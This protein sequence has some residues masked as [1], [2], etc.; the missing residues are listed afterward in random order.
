MTGFLSPS[1]KLGYMFVLGLWFLHFPSLCISP[2]PFY[3]LPF[4]LP[5][6]DFY[7]FIWTGRVEA[8][9][10]HLIRREQGNS[11]CSLVLRKAAIYVDENSE[12]QKSLCI[13]PQRAWLT[14]WVRGPCKVQGKYHT[15]CARLC[16]AVKWAGRRAILAY[17]LFCSSPK[18][19]SFP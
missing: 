16:A 9:W 2:P 3:L 4:S 19:T 12:Q 17:N 18:W 10:K 14:G 6:F 11:S 15:W 5:L 7:T 8:K 13:T 1:Y